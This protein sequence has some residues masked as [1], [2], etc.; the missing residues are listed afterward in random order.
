MVKLSTFL[1]LFVGLAGPSQ[2][3]GL[4]EQ[5]VLLN[6]TITIPNAT[7]IIS[8][9]TNAPTPAPTTG[10]CR[11]RENCGRTRGVH[12]VTQKAVRNVLEKWEKGV[13]VDSDPA[14]VTS[15]FCEEALLWG[16]VSEHIRTDQASIRSY[17]DFF[18]TEGTRI[19]ESCG[20]MSRTGI[21]VVTY[22]RSVKWD[23]KGFDEPVCARMTFVVAREHRRWCIKSL[24]SSQFPKEPEELL[25][26]DRNNSIT[27]PRPN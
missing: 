10:G 3:L 24:H 5:K 9:G 25:E 20:F 27:F 23:L 17:F 21:N 1:A 19:K 12:W 13:S 2:G 8:K 16:T 14:L 6:A 26:I 11:T 7:V 4:G 15:L 22:E 18:A